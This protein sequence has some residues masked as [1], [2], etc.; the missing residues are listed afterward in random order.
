M[1]LITYPVDDFKFEY[2]YGLQHSTYYVIH[3]LFLLCEW[4]VLVFS[5][6]AQLWTCRCAHPPQPPSSSGAHSS[7]CDWRKPAGSEE[8]RARTRV[9][10]SAKFSRSS[11][12]YCSSHTVLASSCPSLW[13]AATSG[14]ICGRC[15]R[16]LETVTYPKVPGN[17]AQRISVWGWLRTSWSWSAMERAAGTRRTVSAAG[18]TR[19]W[20]RPGSRRQREEDR[21]WK[22]PENVLWPNQAF[23]GSLD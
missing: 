22:V 9:V 21:P 12:L 8:E 5:C 7:Q 3:S 11:S 18:S 15:W 1:S 13:C 14:Q 19:T 16:I 10:I 2:V 20:V 17:I 6:D 23:Y 4:S